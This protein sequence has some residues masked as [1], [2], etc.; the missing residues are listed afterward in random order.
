MRIRSAGIAGHTEFAAGLLDR[1]LAAERL[2]ERT[3]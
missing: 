3:L 1:A 2:G